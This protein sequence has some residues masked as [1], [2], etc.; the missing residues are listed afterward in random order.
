[1]ELVAYCLV[2]VVVSVGSF[3]LAGSLYGLFHRPAIYFPLSL[4]TKM[5]L[6]ATFGAL[7]FM[8]G[9]VVLSTLVFKAEMKKRDDYKQLPVLLVGALIS[10]LC[11]VAIYF[12]AL[13]LAWKILG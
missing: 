5:A 13:S 1:M 6:C 10:V 11:T 7:L 8:V 4:A 2:I 3:W 12:S 9:G